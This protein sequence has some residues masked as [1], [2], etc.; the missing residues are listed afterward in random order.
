MVFTCKMILLFET[1]VNV[2]YYMALLLLESIKL[3]E[4]PSVARSRSDNAL[5]SEQRL[6]V[7]QSFTEYKYVHA[8][9]LY[10]LKLKVKVGNDQEMTQSER[11]LHSKNRGGKKKLI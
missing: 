3:I 7:R 6:E 2:L 11:N 10:T 9:T 5:N 8:C 4:L 1:Y